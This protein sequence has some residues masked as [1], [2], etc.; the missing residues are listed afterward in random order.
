MP[1]R[2]RRWVLAL[3]CVGAAARAGDV[4]PPA[5]FDFFDFLGV[6]VQQDGEWIDPID[7]EDVAVPDDEDGMAAPTDPADDTAEAGDE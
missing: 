6:M 3:L 2:T 4:E 1:V 7:M 5:E